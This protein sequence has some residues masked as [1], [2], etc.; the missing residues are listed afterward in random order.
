MVGSAPQR[1]TESS[2]SGIRT[3]RANSTSSWQASLSQETRRCSP[4]SR[5]RDRL[6]QSPHR[7]SSCAPSPRPRHAL[8]HGHQSPPRR[9]APLQR[10]TNHVDL[11]ARP[12]QQQ[13]T[14]GRRPDRSRY[15]QG[16]RRPQFL[17]NSGR[18]GQSH[19][20]MLARLRAILA[21]CA[22]P[23]PRSRSNRARD[24][25]RAMAHR[26]RM[27]RLRMSSQTQEQSRQI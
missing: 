13:A 11:M 8:R 5:S 20:G 1:Q 17:Q 15:Q 7:R 18:R 19:S 9:P 22:P 24:V 25:L 2:Q 3:D 12:Q 4:R 27:Q 16:Q 6:G 26:R 14:S 10:E 21:R 23:A